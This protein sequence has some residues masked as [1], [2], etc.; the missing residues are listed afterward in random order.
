[1]SPPS[2]VTAALHGQGPC[3]GERGLQPSS[4]PDLATRP[5]P[6]PGSRPP[7]L[8]SVQGW[9]PVGGRGLGRWQPG[10]PQLCWPDTVPSPNSSELGV[11]VGAGVLCLGVGSWL[12]RG[13]LQGPQPPPDTHHGGD[14]RQGPHRLLTSSLGQRRG[15]RTLQSKGRGAPLDGPGRGAHLSESPWQGLRRGGRGRRRRGH[16]APDQVCGVSVLHVIH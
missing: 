7:L 13:Q 6:W 1:M 9:L 14:P 10:L 11:A 15:D 16:L 8:S 2:P 4:R 5:Q 12:E 3:Q